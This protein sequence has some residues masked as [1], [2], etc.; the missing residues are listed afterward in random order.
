VSLRVEIRPDPAAVARRAAEIVAEEARCAV[1]AQGS[2][3]LAVSG[4]RS[5][6]AMFADLR[7]MDVA[8]DRVLTYQVDERVAPD[9][10]PDRNLTTLMASLPGP[11]A[12][13]L[14]PMPV[15]DVDL[16]AAAAAYASSLP[17]SFDLI[18][19]GIGSDGHTASLIPGD[20]VCEVTDRDIA[21]TGLY[22]GRR[23][24]T[25]TYPVLNRATTILWLITGDDK[26]DALARLRA[27]DRSIPAGRVAQ[28]HG[29]VIADAAA[30]G[31]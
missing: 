20:P 11:A 19:L 7:D 31:A 8:W 30:A 28:D 21:L 18:H 12:G 5:P 15:T 2:F 1:A 16:E 9:G 4:G 10:D 24:M 29:I 22:Q 14:R 26:A 13:G 3:A 6:W 23:R 27:G 25:M 17:P